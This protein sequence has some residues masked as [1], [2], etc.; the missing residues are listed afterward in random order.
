MDPIWWSY[1]GDGDGLKELEYGVVECLWH[2][3]NKYSRDVVG[4]M[5]FV[6]RKESE[7]FVEDC[8]G[9]FAY[10]H[11]LCRGRC[12]WDCVLPGERAVGVNVGI[13]GEPSSFYLFDDGYDLCGVVRD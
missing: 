5:C 7:G 4:A 10:D 1:A 13:G 9:E 2:V 11:V 12:G 3:Y 6:A 8:G